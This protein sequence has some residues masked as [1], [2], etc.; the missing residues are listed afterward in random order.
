[1]KVGANHRQVGISSSKENDGIKISS[2]HMSGAWFVSVDLRICLC[3]VLPVACVNR[4][5]C[6]D[7]GDAAQQ[8]AGVCKIQ[9]LACN[10]QE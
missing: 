9:N 8:G 3:F 7:E 4:G 6:K 10:M 2:L 1:M 5:G